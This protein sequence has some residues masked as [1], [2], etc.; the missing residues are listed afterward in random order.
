MSTPRADIF[1]A[2]LLWGQCCVGP[3][4]VLLH[5]GIRSEHTQ[6]SADAFFLST[7]SILTYLILT[8]DRDARTNAYDQ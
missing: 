8:Q 7:Y 6:S 1:T 5:L 4:P 2:I 3:H